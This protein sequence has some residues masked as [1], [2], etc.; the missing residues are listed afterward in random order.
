MSKTFVLMLIAGMFS[1]S[2][3]TAQVCVHNL[4]SE[5]TPS[6]DF[7]DNEDGTATHNTTGLMWRQCPFKTDV[8]DGECAVAVESDGR[9]STW[10]SA[11][12]G[13]DNLIYG[14]YSDWRLPN[15]TELASIVEWTCFEQ[16]I[17]NDIFPDSG[18]AG[19]QFWSSTTLRSSQGKA[20]VIQFRTGI[21]SG[22][23]KAT[24]LQF[25][26]VRDTDEE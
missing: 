13:A 4:A 7:T 18:D 14:G 23:S 21:E 17:N 8:E 26:V 19:S 9:Y 6:S 2:A 22:V 10:A 11:L 24:N 16:A 12:E 5:S 20:R 3:W 15:I 25:F 1:T